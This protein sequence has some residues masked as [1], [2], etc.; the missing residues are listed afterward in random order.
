MV[1]PEPGEPLLL[2]I[3]ATSE[4]VSMV[5]VAERPGPHSL[6]ELGSSSADGLESQDSRPVEE[7]GTAD[8]SGS[9]DPGPTEELPRPTPMEMDAPDPPWEGL[10]HPASGVLHQRGTPRCQY[11]VP[12]GPQA[13][14]C[15]PHRLQEATP[16]LPGSQ[17]LSG[18]LIHAE[19]RPPQP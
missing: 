5:L 19:G 7:P 9:H 11:K 3:T 4:A 12:G 13:A 18:D 8:G 17:D 2:Y 6:H 15:S 10:D 1:A 14:L 16:L